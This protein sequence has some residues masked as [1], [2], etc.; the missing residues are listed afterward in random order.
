MCAGCCVN[1]AHGFVMAQ[2]A[3]MLVGNAVSVGGAEPTLDPLALD[4]RFELLDAAVE[5]FFLFGGDSGVGGVG[6]A[7]AGV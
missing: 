5:S 1:V 6:V 2:L 4:C 7:A 3:A